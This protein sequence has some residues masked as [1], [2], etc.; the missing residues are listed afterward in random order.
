[1]ELDTKNSKKPRPYLARTSLTGKGFIICQKTRFFV[2]CDN[3]GGKIHV[4]PS[5]SSSHCP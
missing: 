2:S 3:K 1:M 5:H 4:D